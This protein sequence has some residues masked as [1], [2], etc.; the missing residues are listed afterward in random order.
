MNSCPPRRN[1]ASH[2]RLWVDGAGGFDLLCGDEVSFGGPLGAGIADVT[3][4]AQLPRA[5]GKLVRG[6]KLGGQ[7]AAW[8][9]AGEDQVQWLRND[10]VIELSPQCR[11]RC[12]RTSQLCQTWSFTALAPSRFA[13]G[14]DRVLWVDQVVLMGEA[15][16]NH[17]R[18][19]GLPTATLMW[20]ADSAQWVW[21]QNATASWENLQCDQ[22]LAMGDVRMMLETVK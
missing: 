13:S 3:L 17:I 22:A 2:W 4:M 11:L 18:V 21:R 8:Q 12:H 9:L 1:L 16:S 7:D 20:Q 6:S 15:A 5:V 14:I 19:D 10:E